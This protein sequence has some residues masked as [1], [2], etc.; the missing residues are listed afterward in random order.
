[1]RS[2]RF[3]EFTCPPGTVIRH[4]IDQVGN[5]LTARLM[6]C[7]THVEPVWVFGD[8]SY[9]CPHDLAVGWN[10]DVVHVIT[11]PPWEDPAPQ[12]APV[13]GEG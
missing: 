2:V 3:T 1:M 9:E 12:A 7:A 6:W 10:S 8:G 5:N 11:T 4:S 13:G